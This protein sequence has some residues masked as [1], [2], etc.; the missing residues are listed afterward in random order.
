LN[1][2]NLNKN[3]IYGR[4]CSVELIN[5]IEAKKFI[6]RYH[7]QGYYRAPIRLGLKYNNKLVSIMTFGKNRIAV[8]NKKE[9]YEL[10]RYVSSDHVVGGASKLFKYFINNYNPTNITTYADR[11]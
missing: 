7:I 6:D 4:N 9:G 2:L 11:R 1:I 5:N 10:I 3:S 8:G